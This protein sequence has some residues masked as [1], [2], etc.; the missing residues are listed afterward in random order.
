MHIMANARRVRLGRGR[1]SAIDETSLPY[2]ASPW[3]LSADS[4][5]AALPQSPSVF[6][7]GN[8]FIGLRA[9]GTD[10]VP[11]TYLNGV[12]EKAP[13]S[14]HEAAFGYARESDTRLPVAEAARL[15]LAV[16]G[17]P[18]GLPDLAELDMRRG[19]LRQ[20]WRRDGVEVRLERLVSMARRSVI[21]TR[22]TARAD[23][24]ARLRVE[25]L[26]P[27]VPAGKAECDGVYDPRIGPAIDGAWRD[28]KVIDEQDCR[29]RVDRLMR[30]G[31][32]VA[33]LA[34][35]LLAD[36]TLEPG[37]D[38][39]G[40]HFAVYAASRS[41]DPLPRATEQLRSAMNAG[42]DALAE[43][44][45]RWFEAFWTDAHVELPASPAFECALRHALFQLAQA[46]GDGSCSVSAKGQTGEG[47]EGHVFWDAEAYVL[48][49]FAAVRPEVA[50][51]ML[52]WRIERLPAARRHARLMGHARGAL[53]PWRTIEGDEC[54]AYF[55]AGSAQYH[56]NAGIAHALRLYLAHSGD[57]TLLAEGGAEMLVETAQIW[58]EAGFHDPD[59]GGAFVIN[60]VT[61]PDEYSALVDNNLYTNLM[62]AEHLRFAAEAG[63]ELLAPGEADAM[64]RAADAMLLPFDKDREVF[65]QDD[66]FFAR[67]SWPFDS[68]PDSDYPLLLHYHPLTI[69]RHQVAKQADAVLATIFCRDAFDPPM[70]RR[71][72]D[73]Y[74]DVTVHDSTLSPSAFAAAAAG[75]GDAERAL[76]YWRATVMTDLANLFGNSDHG[77]HMAALAGGWTALAWGF[78]GM[79]ACGDSLSFQPIAAPELGPYSFR[80]CWRGAR[81]KVSVDGDRAAYHLLE[82]EDVEILHCG[83]PVRLRAG[84][85]VQPE[86][87]A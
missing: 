51:A 60:R 3:R 58:L 70:R 57:K 80:V 33:A 12:Y 30:S 54:S 42:F 56:L 72:L 32:A 50:R 40:V 69:Y 63:A 66:A 55:P 1:L 47:Y 83:R 11:T 87:A 23:R 38:W 25:A 84:V 34:S 13:I 36:E 46:T 35:P 76:A 19:L 26:A 28:V 31:F 75:S 81:I 64:L 29:G 17:Q 6:A 65:A 44:Q 73:V 16:D 86:L 53:Y 74:E 82:G 10:G 48:P 5:A 49:V 43:E 9:F 21:A 68:T 52:A 85:A 14:Y 7:L 79:R 37:K 24:R 27:E 78:A 61:G 8:G 71:M 41:G 67:K 15:R 59:R 18:L 20:I 77:L 22:V 45:A 62:A 2:E 39:S 4:K